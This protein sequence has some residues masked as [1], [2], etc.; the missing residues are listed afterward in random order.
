MKLQHQATFESLVDPLVMLPLRWLACHPV[1]ERKVDTV[2]THKVILTVTGKN[3]KLAP[4]A[5]SLRTLTLFLLCI[6]SKR[7]LFIFSATTKKDHFPIYLCTYVK[8]ERKL[9]RSYNYL[10]HSPIR[11]R[12]GAN[13]EVLFQMTY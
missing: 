5:K 4:S 11:C 7:S 3:S 1:F 12:F 2:M 8:N 6:A 13:E 9:V 10:L